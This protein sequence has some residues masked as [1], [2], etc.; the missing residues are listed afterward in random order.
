MNSARRYKGIGPRFDGVHRRDSC[1]TTSLFTFD[2]LFEVCIVVMFFGKLQNKLR[3]L[4]IRVWHLEDEL[5]PQINEKKSVQGDKSHEIFAL[6]ID[7]ARKFVKIFP[8]GD[9]G[10]L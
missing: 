9:Q 10:I 4:L 1:V 8:R 6:R 7:S 2:S 3:F 5:K